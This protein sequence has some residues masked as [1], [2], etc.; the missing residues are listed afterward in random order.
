MMLSIAF[1]SF[2]ILWLIQMHISDKRIQFSGEIR[3]L[4]GH[5]FSL[6]KNCFIQSQMPTTK[7][8]FLFI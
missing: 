6:S 3:Y 2:S 5:Y 7:M 4:Q 8:Q 1:D